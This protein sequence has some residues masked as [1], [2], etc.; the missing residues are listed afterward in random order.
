MF[1]S[2]FTEAVWEVFQ[3]VGGIAAVVLVLGF[4]CQS[5]VKQLFKRDL[6]QQKAKLQ[7]ELATAK[8]EI[9][10]EANRKLEVLKSDLSRNHDR[11]VEKFKATLEIAAHEKRTAFEMMHRVRADS[12]AEVYTNMVRAFDA[13]FA[14]RRIGPPDTAGAM[15]AQTRVDAF[16]NSFDSKRIFFT[17][18][19]SPHLLA[20]NNEMCKVIEV[21]RTDYGHG[22]T[23]DQLREMEQLRQS[24]TNKRAF[25]ADEFRKILGIV[26]EYPAA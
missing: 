12:V 8:N 25:L 5:F 4:L 24:I 13:V 2:V 26:K 14:L 23:D 6:E 1:A 11:E 17:E 3:T 18:E 21:Y 7:L 15:A 16:W 10:S 19:L 20:I 9:E 22:P